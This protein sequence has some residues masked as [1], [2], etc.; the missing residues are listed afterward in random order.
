MFRLIIVSL[1]LSACGIAAVWMLVPHSP[2]QPLPSG[3]KVEKKIEARPEP[4]K[5]RRPSA[6]TMA[7]TT[8]GQ[9]EVLV[10]RN[11]NPQEMTEPIIIPDGTLTIVEKQVVPSAKEG[12]LK[13]IGT[14]VQE[15]EVVP[16]EKQLPEIH[17][18]FL[19]VP[20]GPNDKPIDGETFFAHPRDGRTMYRRARRTDSLEPE[21]VDLLSIKLTVRKLEVGDRVHRG[22]L[23]A[24]VDPQKQMDDVYR[25]IAKLNGT[26]VER[27]NA[28]DQE[29]EFSRRYNTQLSSN[30]RTP[31]SIPLDSLMETH[32]AYLKHRSE[33]EV[34]TKEIAGAQSELRAAWTDLQMHE[35]HA[36]IDGVIKVIYKHHQGEA[37]KPFEPVLEIQNS[38]RLRV[39]GRLEEQESRKLAVGMTAIVEATRPQAPRLVISGHLNTVNCVAVSKGERPVIVSGSDDETLRGWDSLTGEKVWVV[40]GLRSAVRSVACTPPASQRN[41]ACFGCADGTVRLLD[42]DSPDEKKPREMADRHRGPVLGVAFSPDGEVIATCGDD[43]LIRLWKTETGALLHVLPKHSGPVTSVQFAS[44]T[45]LVSAAKDNRLIVW[46]VEAGKPPRAIGPRFDGRGGEVLTVG[47]SP[48][49]KTVLFDQGKELRVLTL[50][51]QQIVGTL[52]NPSDAQNFST[53]AIFSPDG[54]TILTNGSSSGKLQLWRAPVT[55][56][57]GSELRQFIW[58][59]TATCGAFAPEGRAFAVTGTQDHKVLV[60][61]LPSQEEID[62]RLEARLTLVEKDLDTHSRHV[63]VWAELDSPEWL[64]PGMRATMVVLPP[65]K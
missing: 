5:A 57:R 59:G 15:G 36:A 50:D 10:Y 46:D 12:V 49:G 31:G 48:D 45:R 62:S 13:I 35:I 32:L 6:R 21:K 22:Q 7:S 29:A 42:L 63:R 43:R 20:V 8:A 17:L 37:V 41:L 44:A 56:P 60:W 34:K 1:L 47:V 14:V 33:K 19:A 11:S 54:K 23:L 40:W 27:K 39:E 58:S 16:P 18:G 30:R 55:Q 9:P 24:V 4:Q 25:K 26:E 2:A 28:E 3:G 52:Q 61:T 65:R 38:S 64:I 51:K 53:M